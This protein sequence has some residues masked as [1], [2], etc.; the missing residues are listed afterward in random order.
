MAK[1]L[2]GVGN[3]PYVVQAGERPMLVYEAAV[4][5]LGF[6]G[7]AVDKHVSLAGVVGVS[8]I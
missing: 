1:I 7:E 6:P 8:G 2:W 4:E 3:L 5:Q